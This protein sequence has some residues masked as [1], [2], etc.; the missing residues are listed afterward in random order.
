MKPKFEDKAQTTTYTSWVGYHS[1]KLNL[2]RK[3]AIIAMYCNLKPPDA[4]AF[5]I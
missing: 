3:M 2:M 4:I 5:S 1:P